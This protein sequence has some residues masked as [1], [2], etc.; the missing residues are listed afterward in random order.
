MGRTFHASVV[1][2]RERQRALPGLA[3]GA[4]C[5][6]ANA[7]HASP[8]GQAEYEFL[9]I[10][11]LEAYRAAAGVR[12]FDQNTWQI[13]GEYG[14]SHGITL[15]GKV[16]YGLQD[17]TSGPTLGDTREGIVDADFFV[18]KSLLR[19]GNHVI[20]TQALYAP[21]TR[22]ASALLGDARADDRDESVQLS[23]LY[24]GGSERAFV[25]SS[26]GVR[27]SLG[28]DADQL[29]VDVS[30]GWHGPWGTMLMLE[31]NSIDALNSAGV[32]E[33]TGIP[34]QEFDLLSVSPS[35]VATINDNI[36][37]QMGGRFDLKGENLDLGN[38]AFAALWVGGRR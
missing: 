35:V 5:M 1:F 11:R 28:A 26:V 36:R 37:F 30:A 3:V 2:P 7:A 4:I 20:S 6:A 21:S 31:A 25:S 17:I 38:G 8:W 14:A 33:E 24:G 9:V 23:L 27:Y 19:R 15:G 12:E 32:S 10:Q 29:R 16:A 34:G 18:Q 22:P 13:Y